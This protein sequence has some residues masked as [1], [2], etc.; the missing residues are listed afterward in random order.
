VAESYPVLDEKERRRNKRYH[1]SDNY[2]DFYFR[3]IYPNKSELILNGQITGFHSDYNRYL[4]KV[5]EK[6]SKEFIEERVEMLPFRFS[7]IGRWWHKETEIDLV[8]LNEMD[9]EI[10]FVE[11]KWRNLDYRSAIKIIGSLKEKSRHFRWNDDERIEY[12]GV[13]AKNIQGKEELRRG[14]FVA[15]DLNDS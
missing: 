5:F 4:G 14:G 6:F 8:A 9:K 3:F 1:L 13:M 11:C 15:F 2:F 12:F 10:L 7:R